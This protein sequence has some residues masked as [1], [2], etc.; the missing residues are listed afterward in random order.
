MDENLVYFGDA[1]KALGEGKVGG[2]IVRW[3]N[4]KDVDLTGDYF[5]PE[6]DLGIE[7]GD[8]LP[9]YY[10]HGYDG[11][12]KNRKLG[13]GGVKFDDVGAW[14]DA[15]L[16]MRDEY[17]EQIYKLAE[18]G[19]L[20]WSTG[21]AGHL[22]ERVS[23]GKSW[24]IKSWPIAEASLTTQPAE[25]RNAAVPVKSLYQPDESQDITT[26]EVTMT[27]EIKAPTIDVEAIVSS[28]VEKALK[29]YEESRPQVKAGFDVVED[30][31]DRAAKGNPFTAGEFF[32][33]VKTAATYPGQEDMRLKPLKAT[34][35][36]E[37]M[38]S[39]G[40]YLVPP[41]IAA[42]VQENMFGVGSLL[43]FF[44]PIQVEG[45]SLT[46]NA[47]D[48]TSRA[49]GSRMGG[50]Q[51][52]WMAEAG[53][54]TASKPKFRQIELK[55]KKCA[56]LCYATD[57]LLDDATA[58]QSWITNSVPQELRFKVEQAI[59]NGDGTGKPLGMLQAGCLVSAVRTDA[60][61]IDALDLARMWAARYPGASDYVWL[62]NSSIYPQLFNLSVGQMPVYLP[63]G[64]LS[65]SPYGQ[66]FGRPVV[67]TEYNPYL[68][69]LGDIMLVSPSQY[70]M[71]AKGG[72]QSAS[73]IHVN[74]VY[75]ETAFRFVY[76]V[77]GQPLW[78]SAITA[79]DGTSSLSPF[80]ALAAST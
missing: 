51:G 67:E 23:I 77:D 73:S 72:V 80:V 55:L 28:A 31:A 60:S 50:V 3:G 19:K 8:R 14:L 35:L 59:V 46:I 7:E 74:F 39:E 24:E 10:N 33:A 47:V 66:I 11:V 22:V 44:N 56:A 9:V 25:Y 1:V 61:E 49:D 65:A 20:G 58:L 75:D 29:S 38:P 71:I 54:K 5:T 12:M 62:A 43:S 42:G 78:A 40:G 2:Y 69:T 48:E 63:A 79:Y 70:A 6:T 17:E 36:N 37:A 32:Q 52:Y 27:E 30:E 16:E 57:E 13:K 4:P 68:G 21:A 64:G 41:Q 34:G 76:R 26:E 15:Q 53:T 45:N 18:A